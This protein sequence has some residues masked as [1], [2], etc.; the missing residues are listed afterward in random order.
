MKV[1]PEKNIQKFN[2]MSLSTIISKGQL[3]ENINELADSILAPAFD[4]PSIEVNNVTV[5]FNTSKGLYTAVKDINLTVKKGEIISL[6]GHS[7]C[8]KSTLMGTIS[9]M[10]KPSEGEVYANGKKVTS[11]G[12]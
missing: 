12:T 11:P 10:V 4:S 2:A 3:A 9:G 5:S 7:G 6:I 1:N 8:G